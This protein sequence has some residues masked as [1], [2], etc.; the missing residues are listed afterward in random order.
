METSD[1]AN[2]NL[3][4]SSSQ[5]SRGWIE[6]DVPFSI[7][8]VN[9]IELTIELI[10]ITFNSLVYDTALGLPQTSGAIWMR[11]LAVW[12]NAY[13]AMAATNCA[14]KFFR[15]NLPTVS[16]LSCKMFMY[17]WLMFKVNAASHLSAFAVDR[18]ICLNFPVWHYQKKWPSIIRKASFSIVV[19]NFV[20]VTNVL[21]LPNSKRHL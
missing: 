19:F 18:V 4:F 5:N 11:Y 9:I 15:V 12:D 3:S 8:L 7:W 6:G 16:N 10:G 2:D 17:F 1:Y 13:L 14:T 21:F 20:L